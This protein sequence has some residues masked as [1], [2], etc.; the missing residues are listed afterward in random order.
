MSGEVPLVSPLINYFIYK[1]IYIYYILLFNHL[2]VFIFN[3]EVKV[4]ANRQH[5]PLRSQNANNDPTET[6]RKGQKCS[7]NLLRKW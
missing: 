1:H 5:H 6:T 2:F 7:K 3:I 4:Q